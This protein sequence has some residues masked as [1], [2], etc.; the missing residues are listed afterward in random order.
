M[1]VE[2]AYICAICGTPHETVDARAECETKCIKK[3]NEEEAKLKINK[4]K[5]ERL[6]NEKEINELLNKADTMLRDH[7]NKYETFAMVRS[8]YYLSYLFRK[9]HWFF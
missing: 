8:Y 9:S 6:K 3:R 5:E 7:L 2:N 1:N 4:E